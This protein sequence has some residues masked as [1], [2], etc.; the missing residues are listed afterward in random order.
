MHLHAELAAGEDHL[1]QQ[2]RAGRGRR[3][4]EQ[5]GRSLFKERAERLPAVRTT[6]NEAIVSR[7]PDL[8]ERLDVRN[9]VVPRG[10]VMIAPNAGDK[11][12]LN[13]EGR[14]LRDGRVLGF[15]HMDCSSFP[16]LWGNCRRSR[17]ML[18]MICRQATVRLA[19]RARKAINLVCADVRSFA[20]G[21][22]RRPIGTIEPFHAGAHQG[23]IVQQDRTDKKALAK[24]MDV[25]FVDG[26]KQKD[27]KAEECESCH[28]GM[29]MHFLEAW[30]K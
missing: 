6:F 13:T 20:D 27:G 23:R 15:N 24:W 16:I 14:Q 4:T 1:D 7:E 19:R 2:R 18:E 9:A 17:L 29:E 3:R 22:E 30:G 25:S 10:Q 28:V 5:S 26:F 12:R 11:L 8:S 21:L